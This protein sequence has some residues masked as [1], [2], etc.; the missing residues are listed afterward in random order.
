MSG[1]GKA[2]IP[3]QAPAGTPIIGQAFTPL[4]VGVP[5]IM[6]L[7]CNC[8]PVQDRLPL[9]IHPLAALARLLVDKGILTETE[10]AV[11]ISATA[12]CPSCRKTYSVFL[13]PQN[14]QTQVNMTPPAPEEVPQ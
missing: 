6:T 1:N 7:T 5:M 9:G 12:T 2:P 13:N 14:M 4:T 11:A 10:Y 8:G 3:F